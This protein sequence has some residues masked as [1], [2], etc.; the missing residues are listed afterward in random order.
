MANYMEG[1]RDAIKEAGAK[2]KDL[3]RIPM[4]TTGDPY[5]ELVWDLEG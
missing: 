4:L 5:C 3:D 2:L 1:V